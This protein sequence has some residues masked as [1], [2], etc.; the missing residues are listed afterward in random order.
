MECIGRQCGSPVLPEWC[1]N[2][3]EMD[4]I[5]FAF[6]FYHDIYSRV[7]IYGTVR[8]IVLA[9]CS[10]KKRPP[11]KNK[12]FLGLQM[13]A[14]PGSQPAAGRSMGPP[15]RRPASRA[16]AQPGRQTAFGLASEQ[17]AGRRAGLLARQAARQLPARGQP[18]QTPE[19]F[20][21]FFYTSVCH[22]CETVTKNNQTPEKKS[23]EEALRRSWLARMSATA[24]SRQADRLYSHQLASEPASKLH[25][26][27]CPQTADR[28]ARQ[29]PC[30]QL[31]RRIFHLEL[32]GVYKGRR[33]V[34]LFSLARNPGNNN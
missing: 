9:N 4:S 2:T 6:R 11:R 5:L 19:N 32:V 23:S 14:Q 1:P 25:D 33:V 27:P 29:Q 26:C 30:N 24:A 7:Y 28:L 18:V 17:P 12:K 22:F 8:L 21:F 10:N 3:F 13:P 20:R 16:A 34:L 15:A 31:P